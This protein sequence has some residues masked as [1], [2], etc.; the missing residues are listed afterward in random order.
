MI[1]CRLYGR[2]GNLCFQIATTIGH[3]KKYGF[4]WNI[5]KETINPDI[6]P[7]HPFGNLPV[8]QGGADKVWHEPAHYYCEIPAEDGL[9]LD[10]YFQSYKYF[11]HCID[12]VRNQFRVP[13]PTENDRNRIIIHVRKGDYVLYPDKHPVLPIS[14]YVNAVT[15]IM[16]DHGFMQVDIVGDDFDYMNEIKNAIS[17]ISN[18]M[19]TIKIISDNYIQDFYQLTKYKYVVIANSSFSLMASILN[20]NPDKVV[21]CPDKSQYFG[22]GNAHLDTRDIY[23]DN[24]IQIPY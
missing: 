23:P 18:N 24:F 16:H 15:K 20:R 17:G 11:E 6:W 8:Y 13:E 2:Y 1:T 12:E 9:I 5:P 4:D 19:W 22:I 7:N 14:Y 21:I 10:G 3:A